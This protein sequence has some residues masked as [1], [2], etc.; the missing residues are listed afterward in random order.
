MTKPKS[1]P[2]LHLSTDELK[3]AHYELLSIAR[4]DP[5]QCAYLR[6]SNKTYLV[7]RAGSEL[8]LMDENDEFYRAVTD[9]I[10]LIAK[11]EPLEGPGSS[12][13]LHKLDER[14]T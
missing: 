9:E 12:H 3:R 2:V 8:Y 13:H 1:E 5:V 11:D 10:G 7:I 6:H 14:I 4:G